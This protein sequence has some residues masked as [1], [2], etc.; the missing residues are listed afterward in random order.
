MFAGHNLKKVKY[1]PLLALATFK[2]SNKPS[3]RS[4]PSPSLR[5]SHRAQNKI[6]HIQ[7]TWSTPTYRGSAQMWQEETKDPKTVN[8]F[9]YRSGT[10]FAL[11]RVRNQKLRMWRVAHEESIPSDVSFHLDVRI[12]IHIYS[13]TDW[14]GPI[15]GSPARQ[16]LGRRTSK[17]S[18]PVLILPRVCPI[19]GRNPTHSR[20]RTPILT[21]T[22]VCHV[23][24]MP[25]P[26]P[27]S[28]LSWEWW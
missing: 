2:S 27:T 24:E 21:F 17:P 25:I 13:S 4:S 7:P 18:S 14:R 3:S 10:K 1:E 6:P 11:N 26:P 9:P 22:P 19:G 23:S 8:C 28:M 16:N 20:L 12:D 15:Y 5:L